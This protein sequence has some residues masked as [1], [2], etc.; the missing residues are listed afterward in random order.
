MT[1]T[2]VL[3]HPS[4]ENA[5]TP[6]KTWRLLFLDNFENN[7]QLK[8]T[9]KDEGYAV[10]SA[11]TMQDAWAFLDGKDHV[12]V[13][14]CAAHLQEESVFDFLK[15]VRE[16]EVHRDVTFLILSLE[17]GATGARLDH[18]AA[19]SGMA[20]GASAYLIMPKFDTC[21]LLAQIKQLQPSVPRLQQDSASHKKVSR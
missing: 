7:R 9:C 2:P 12:D 5:K 16:N 8:L 10:V 13:I 19:R 17:P 4:D 18:S 6:D 3:E 20:L 11:L 15:A 14:V 21:E 1:K